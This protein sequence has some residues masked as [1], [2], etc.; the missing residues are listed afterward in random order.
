MIKTT[1][2]SLR[3][4]IA[5][6]LTLIMLVS[7]LPLNAIALNDDYGGGTSYSD[8]HEPQA[9]SNTDSSSS[10]TNDEA[11]Q[12]DTAFADP[13]NPDDEQGAD[14]PN[15]PDEPEAD[16]LLLLTLYDRELLEIGVRTK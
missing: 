7:T 9:D 5:Y 3:T 15:L 10:D 2:K 13:Q 14:T 8:V 1:N 4:T 16:E 12:P 11:P 6:V